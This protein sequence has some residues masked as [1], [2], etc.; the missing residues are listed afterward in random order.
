MA[1][2]IERDFDAN[3]IREAIYGDAFSEGTEKS[4]RNLLLVATVTLVI[5]VFGVAVKST[6]LVPLD[7]SNHPESFITFLAITNIALLMNYALR[8]SNDFLRAGEDWATAKKFIEI[9]RIKR[10][11]RLAQDTEEAIMSGQPSPN[12]NN[13]FD[14]EW[15]EEFSVIRE[16]AIERIREIEDRLAERRLPISVRWI[17]L[18]FFGGLPLLIGFAALT[19]T[20]ENALD[21]LKAVVGL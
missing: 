8:A 16:E 14:D 4:G 2:E 13:S 3:A 12:G 17:R 7:F 5:S 11:R 1:D 18:F 15:W 6:S 19:H 21:F 20:W 10:A 9:E